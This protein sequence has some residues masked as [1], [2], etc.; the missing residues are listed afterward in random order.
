MGS[1][2][3]ERIFDGA[4]EV[5]VH[6]CRSL[7]PYSIMAV[8]IYHTFGYALYRLRVRQS[9]LAFFKFGLKAVRVRVFLSTLS[10][11]LWLYQLIGYA[12]IIP[13]IFSRLEYF[14]SLIS[15]PRLIYVVISLHK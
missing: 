3:V 7:G 14:F 13:S 1:G 8:E 12:I 10:P 11:M 4:G 5:R 2:S 15:F 6:H 9:R